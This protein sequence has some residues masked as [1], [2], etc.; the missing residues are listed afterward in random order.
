MMKNFLHRH[1]SN[2]TSPYLK[3]ALRLFAPGIL[4]GGLFIIGGMSFA[5]DLS[6]TDGVVVKF[7]Q[8][9]K[10]VVRDKLTAGKSVVLTS[11]TDDTAGGQVLPL[12]QVP[13]VG[14][15]G[16]LSFEKS[17]SINTL[18][19]NSMSI[20]YAGAQ[21]G[22]GLSV[23]GFNPSL[24]Y[25]QFSD[26]VIGLQL[27]QGASPVINGSSFLR[28]GVGISA[29]G[30][31]L[32]VISNSQFIQNASAI[33]N[34]TPASVIQAIGNWWGSSTG[35]NDPVGNP[36]GQGDAVSTGVNYGSYL[37]Q[38]PLLNPTISILGSPTYTEV[39]NITLLLSCA[40]AVE[41]R[42]AESGAFT[43]LAYT[44]MVSTLPFTLSAGDGVKNISVQYRAVSGNTV[45]VALAQGLLFDTQ[46]PTLNVTN[47]TEGSYIV[48]PIT[49]AATAT[50]AGGVSKVQFYIDSQ[51]A[52][53]V[54]GNLSNY[55]YAW[56][57]AVVADGGH[58]IKVM[59]YDNAGHSTTLLRNIILSKAAPPPPDTTG[60][61]LSGLT[62]TGSA[63]IGGSILTR[64][65]TLVAAVSDPSGI[66]R[67]E[68][69]LDGVLLSTDSNGA[70]G[71]STFIDLSSIADG[72]HTI[73]IR[74]FDSLGNKSE[75]SIAV[76][77]A[78]AA[79]I[80][81]TITAPVNNTVTPLLSLNFSVQQ[82]SAGC[83]PGECGYNG[84][85]QYC[86]ATG[87]RFESGAGC[88]QQPWRHESAI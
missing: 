26:N 17:S 13:V 63:V 78:L 61:T 47:P 75:T 73:T 18:L 4:A 74:A 67:V 15:W 19:L 71:Y 69:V 50:D 87:Q 23:L 8:D 68:F 35:P 14:G 59:A 62:L 88:G 41:Y 9:A 49:I 81:P 46:G 64:S 55:T 39:P 10:L 52:S 33:T 16:G 27:L 72:N 36:A 56:N 21:G 70:D 43:G 82:C 57:T 58:E 25:M 34:K 2:F 12:P 32:P 83:R 79:P 65:G 11:Q 30:N 1:L 77:V 84:Q 85:I 37:T 6:V 45:T 24:Q 3:R 76:V 29:D 42:V 48:N 44:P 86:R 66:S 60:P 22:A 51:L 5:G 20:R 28:N 80:A 38:V 54:N 7:G 31:S 53:T 40:N